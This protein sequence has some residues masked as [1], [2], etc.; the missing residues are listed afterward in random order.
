MGMNTI[1]ETFKP[2]KLRPDVALLVARLV[3]QHRGAP[4]HRKHLNYTLAKQQLSALC[5]W[6]AS[7]EQCD[8]Q[9]Y[10]A[11]TAAYVRGV[12]L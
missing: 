5:G 8:Q 10:D 7:R 11:A 6:H 9:T 2:E 4:R 3:Q 12:S 1:A